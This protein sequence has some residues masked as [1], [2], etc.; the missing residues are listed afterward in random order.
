MPMTAALQRYAEV[1][2]LTQGRF[3]S[4]NRDV[5]GSSARK[6]GENVLK[7]TTAVENA[8][9]RDSVVGHLQRNPRAAFEAENP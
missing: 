6:S 2:R 8:Q 7:I 9:D 1:V 4:T 3:H 5:T